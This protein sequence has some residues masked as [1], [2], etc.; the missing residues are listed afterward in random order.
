MQGDRLTLERQKRLAG[1]LVP[2]GERPGLI[3]LVRRNTLANP[4][5]TT[6]KQ[7]WQKN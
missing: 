1:R 3:G 7:T 4:I 5:R 6:E 2:P